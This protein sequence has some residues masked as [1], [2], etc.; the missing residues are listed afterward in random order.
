MRSPSA[1]EDTLGYVFKEESLLV[2]AL[3]HASF[4]NEHAETLRDYERLEFLGDAVLDM[5]TAQIL[6]TLFPQAQEGALSRRRARVVR[7]ESLASLADDIQLL[8]HMRFGEG[9]RKAV[10]GVSRRVLADCYEALVG[11]VFLDGGYPAVLQA[12]GEKLTQTILLSQDPMDYKTDLQEVCH[13]LGMVS[14]QYVVVS[15]EGPDHARVFT[16]EVVVNGEVYGTGV[17]S[18]KK[19]AEHTCAQQA[20]VRLQQERPEAAFW[21]HKG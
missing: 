21:Q 8:D 10:G 5:L 17:G 7:W 1:L 3:T 16:C 11:A 6:F 2:D 19:N 18:S 20:L 12:F 4:A 15:V 14:P 9:Q 13:Q